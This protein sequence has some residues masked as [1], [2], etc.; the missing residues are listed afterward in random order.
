QEILGR[1]AIVAATARQASIAAI[2]IQEPHLRVVGEVSRQDFVFHPRL[3]P[4][5]EKWTENFD[6]LIKIARHPVG[7]GNVSLFISAIFKIEDAAM[8]KEASDDAAH[9]NIVA[10]TGYSRT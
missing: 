10:D 2:A 1:E 3:Q 9:N 7:A 4:G 6:P 8:F 5:I